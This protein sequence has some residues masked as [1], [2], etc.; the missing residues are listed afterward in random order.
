[1]TFH[2]RRQTVEA[3]LAAYNAFDIDGMLA[4]LCEDVTFR[5]IK[6]G[7][8]THETLGLPAFRLL[9]EKAAAMFLDRHQT[10]L[11][12]EDDGD[13]S[14]AAEIRFRGV[15]ANSN[16]GGAAPAEI[17]SLDGRSEFRFRNGKIV[18]IADIS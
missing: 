12:V 18:G 6:D 16:P 1:M 4:L 8:V 5:N 15:L 9:A 17:L 14:I 7:E 3:Y 13:E 2:E 10:L 11:S